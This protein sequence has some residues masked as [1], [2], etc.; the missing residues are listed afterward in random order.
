MQAPQRALKHPFPSIDLVVSTAS[1][2]SPSRSDLRP[3]SYLFREPSSPA[4]VDDLEETEGVD[5][6]F[7][8]EIYT[9]SYSSKYTFDR[10]DR[11]YEFLRCAALAKHDEATEDRESIKPEHIQESEKP[12]D[13]H[14]SKIRRKTSKILS[15]SFRASVMSTWFHRFI[16]F[17]HKH[18]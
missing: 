14:S 8:D 15:S 18:V 12:K 5:R 17:V 16:D 6:S 11:Y 2:S 10:I 4:V 1:F 3:H 13:E 7:T 9:P